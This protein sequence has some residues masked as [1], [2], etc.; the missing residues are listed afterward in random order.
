M[1]DERRPAWN[2]A[3]LTRID[4]APAPV[5]L[6][7]PLA[8]AAHQGPSKSAFPLC[9]QRNS[10][11]YRRHLPVAHAAETRTLGISSRSPRRESHR[12]CG[13]W[14]ATQLTS[15]R[16]RPPWKGR[17]RASSRTERHEATSRQPAR[18]RPSR[19]P[20]HAHR[21][22]PRPW[23]AVNSTGLPEYKTALRETARWRPPGPV[24]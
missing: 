6:T 11:S 1:V 20:S 9:L 2:A 10:R 24:H 18:S 5:A 12:T 8:F 13:A 22:R 16:D 7:P 21:Q 23:R 17:V 19:R 15:S 4:W 3:P 14:R